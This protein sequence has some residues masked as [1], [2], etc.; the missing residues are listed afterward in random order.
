[1]AH[2]YARCFEY[3]IGHGRSDGR[4]TRFVNPSHRFPALQNMDVNFGSLIHPEFKVAVEI[5]S[6][7]ASIAKIDAFHQGSAQTHDEATLHLGHDN[8]RVDDGAAVHGAGDPVEFYRSINA[9]LG[10]THNPL[11]CPSN[12]FE[13][14]V[15]HHLLKGLLQG[16][17]AQS[18][19]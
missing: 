16:R 6:R 1:M 10:L 18:D 4:Q 9:A 8:I 2:P 7:H 12:A 5:G 13:N 11:S 17:P 15:I 14:A 3:P 19:G